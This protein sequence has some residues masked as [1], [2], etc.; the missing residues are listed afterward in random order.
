MHSYDLM[1]HGISAKNK[2]SHC[3]MRYTLEVVFQQISTFLKDSVA[4]V[5]VYGSLINIISID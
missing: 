1:M 4:I 2:A 5:Y 3:S